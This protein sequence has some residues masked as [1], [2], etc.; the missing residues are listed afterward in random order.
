[1]TSTARSIA[2]LLAPLVPTCG[3]SDE[4]GEPNPTSPF[5]AIPAGAEIVFHQDRSIFVMDRTGQNVTQI[6]FDTPRNYEHVAVSHDRNL[7]I[8]NEQLPNPSGDPGG[9]SVL[10]LYDLVRGT[11][12]RLL[13]DFVTAGNGGVAFGPD[14][15]IYFAAKERDVF[16]NPS[17]PEEFLANAAANDVYRMRPEGSGL[18]RLTRT[19]DRGEA[20]VSVSADG[21][22]VAFMALVVTPPGDVTEVSVTRSDGT[23]PRVVFSGGA[24]GVDSVHDPELSPDNTRL[25]FSR[26][27]PNVPPNF[28]DIP[29]ANTA[30]DLYSVA[31]DG[32]ALTRLTAPGPIAIVPHWQ[33]SEIVYLELS[34]SDDYLGISVISPLATDQSGRRIRQGGGIARWIP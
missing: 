17:T 4:P 16:S 11:E 30:H 18:Q 1:M 12:T 22:L 2:L 20:D 6:T 34:D 24:P 28:P 33:G 23:Q 8:A 13:P 15:F 29:A 31:L 32:S 14:G 7:V 27:N 19:T 25:I 10:W 26:V 21:T 3:G 5:R 9:R